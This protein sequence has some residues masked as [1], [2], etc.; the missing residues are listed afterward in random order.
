MLCKHEC[1]VQ[2]HELSACAGHTDVVM[3]FM[4]GGD[5]FEYISHRK[6]IPEAECAPIFRR[7]AQA[8]KHLHSLGVVHRDIKPENILVGNM[9]EADLGV[10]VRRVD[11]LLLPMLQGLNSENIMCV[12]WC[13]AADGLWARRHHGRRRAYP[14]WCWIPWILCPGD[15]SG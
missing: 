2:V 14:G 4:R 15:L 8:V 3:E 5:L 12:T 9:Y 11:C 10:K 7:I 13:G 1:V 6:N